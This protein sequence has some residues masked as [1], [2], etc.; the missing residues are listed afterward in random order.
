MFPYELKQLMQWVGLDLKHCS[1]EAG[2]VHRKYTKR[3]ELRGNPNYSSRPG[4][5]DRMER[6]GCLMGL[7]LE[8]CS[9]KTEK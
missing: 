1:G 8:N 7:D 5:N 3:F 6:I 9:E 4:A 2:G